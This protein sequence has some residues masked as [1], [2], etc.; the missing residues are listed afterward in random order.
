MEFHGGTLW[1]NWSG[2]W[3]ENLS[4][5]LS[6]NLSQNRRRE[7]ADRGGGE[8]G[9]AA[10]HRKIPAE[11][12]HNPLNY[13]LCLPAGRAALASPRSAAK[14]A[15]D[16]PLFYADF[17]FAA[18]RTGGPMLPLSLPDSCPTTP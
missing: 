1:G 8:R 10:L 14:R 3:A 17:L 7:G 5:S 11:V 18:A 4:G 2:S 16:D 13:S 12:C 15:P 6:E 9:P